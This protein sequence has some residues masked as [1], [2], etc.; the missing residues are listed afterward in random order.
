MPLTYDKNGIVTEDADAAYVKEEARINKI[1][2]RQVENLPAEV[3]YPVNKLL[4]TGDPADMPHV[5]EL[6]QQEFAGK[7]S[8]CRSQPDGL[9]RR[10]ER[11]ADD[12]SGWYGRRHGQRAAAGQGCRRL[13]D[14]RQRS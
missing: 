10:L 7:L 12:T 5:E 14:R 8:I 13:P 4:L 3:T 2:V 1:P 11:P 9:R 6:M